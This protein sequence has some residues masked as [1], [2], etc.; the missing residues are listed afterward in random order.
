MFETE[1][2]QSTNEFQSERLM[3]TT[4]LKFYNFSCRKLYVLI[5]VKK[6]KDLQWFVCLFSLDKERKQ[7]FNQRCADLS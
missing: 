6:K 3:R 1:T 2:R 5:K 7:A 4:T